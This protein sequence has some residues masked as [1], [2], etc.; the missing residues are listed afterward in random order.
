VPVW[1]ATDLGLDPATLKNRVAL[2]RLYVPQTETECEFIEGDS[3]EE[4]AEKLAL[5]LREAK[6]I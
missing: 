3:A 4:K 2:E 5:R 1:K 6:L